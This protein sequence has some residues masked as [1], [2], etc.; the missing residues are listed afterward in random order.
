MTLRCDD[1]GLLCIKFSSATPSSCLTWLR[2]PDGLFVGDFFLGV[3][4][5]LGNGLDNALDNGELVYLGD[6][7]VFVGEAVGCRCLRSG[8]GLCFGAATMISSSTTSL[9][10]MRFLGI[11]NGLKKSFML[12]LL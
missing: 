5:L 8:V 6:L 9:I 11:V 1:E 4:P 2:L 3:E 12:L 10:G 7:F